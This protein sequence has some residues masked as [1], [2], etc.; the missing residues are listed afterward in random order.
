MS[1]LGKI[2]RE[3]SPHIVQTDF[4]TTNVDRIPDLQLKH[5]LEFAEQNGLLPYIPKVDEDCHR[6]DSFV[7]NV[8]EL[9]VHYLV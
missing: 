7:V 6:L 1:Y 4:R 5:I 9:F 3:E 2:I 8:R